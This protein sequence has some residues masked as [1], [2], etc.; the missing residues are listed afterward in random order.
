[1]P[2]AI[3]PA[4]VT[5]GSVIGVA[6]RVTRERLSAQP[7]RGARVLHPVGYRG[8]SSGISTA[9]ITLHQFF[10]ILPTRDQPIH[11]IY[12]SCLGG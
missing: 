8:T 6:A 7:R 3:L 10:S 2:Y 4:A 12:T 11:T 9:K 5:I 1:M